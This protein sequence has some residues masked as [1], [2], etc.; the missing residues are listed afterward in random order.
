MRDNKQSGDFDSHQ[1]AFQLDY[2]VRV[3]TH[4]DQNSHFL[5]EG[6][7]LIAIGFI[8]GSIASGFFQEIGKDLWV[9]ANDLARLLF[10]S[11]T[12]SKE[13]QEYTTIVVFSYGGLQIIA[14]LDIKNDSVDRKTLR[15]GND[16]QSTF[17]GSLPVHIQRLIDERDTGAMPSS[18]V[19]AV[20]LELNA[21]NMQWE[22]THYKKRVLLLGP[23][24]LD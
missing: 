3:V 8:F 12:E 4:V 18:D 6:G 5:G 13:K 15:H 24:S 9:K 21:K 20:L 10:E 22:E 1:E 16:L 19:S 14:K 7:I 23:L 17:W 11:H 2:G